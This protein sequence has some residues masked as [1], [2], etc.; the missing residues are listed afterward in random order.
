LACLFIFSCT[1][2]YIFAVNQMT[3]HRSML[4][5]APLA[6]MVS[7]Y[8]VWLRIAPPVAFTEEMGSTEVGAGSDLGPLHAKISDSV[9]G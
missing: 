2:A 9:T 5:F 4:Q 7:C 8:G 1:E 6:I 3:I